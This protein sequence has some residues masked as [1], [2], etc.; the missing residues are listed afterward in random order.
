MPEVPPAPD[1]TA[2]PP[3]IVHVGQ[4]FSGIA[5]RAGS[6]FIA[7]GLNGPGSGT[8]VITG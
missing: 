5:T 7:I 1:G 3:V 8:E 4:G 6:G 2:G